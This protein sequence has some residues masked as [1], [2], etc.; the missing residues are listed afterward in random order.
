MDPYRSTQNDRTGKSRDAPVQSGVSVTQVCLY[1]DNVVVVARLS[2]ATRL[3]PG[4]YL[5]RIAILRLFL[6]EMI[7]AAIE[8]ETVVTTSA[9]TARLNEHF[10]ALRRVPGH[11]LTELAM[12]LSR[13]SEP[14][15][16][17]L[18]AWRGHAASLM[19]AGAVCEPTTLR[20]ST[21]EIVAIDNYR[22]DIRQASGLCISRSAILRATIESFA[23]TFQIQ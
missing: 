9:L 21:A 13:R 18:T 19:G 10:E 2:A 20:L 6:R 3:S 16:A 17:S 12:N 23:H 14:K 22:C 4:G 5:T 7:E 11:P 8:P 1:R 15:V